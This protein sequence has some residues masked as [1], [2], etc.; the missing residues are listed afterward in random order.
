[1][2]PVKVSAI[3]PNYNSL[4][5]LDKCVSMIRDSVDEIIIGDDNSKIKPEYLDPKIS[6]V[7]NDMNRGAAYCR[8]LGI[9]MAV[10][11]NI[12]CLDNDIYIDYEN[13]KALFSNIPKGTIYYPKQISYDFG[14]VMCPLFPK[15]EFYLQNSSIFFFNRGDLSKLDE[16]FDEN[17]RIYHEDSDFFFR[18]YLFGIKT[19]YLPNILAKHDAGKNIGVLK[20]REYLK[21]RN[22][23][24]S[25]LKFF[26][27][28]NELKEEYAFPGYRCVLGYIRNLLLNR[29]DIDKKIYKLNAFYLFNLLIICKAF[30]WNLY[31]LP[32]I[33]TKNLRLK[34]A[35]LQTRKD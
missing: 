31:M 10:N 18:C 34:N 26:G 15:E 8:N 27:I 12:L 4:D 14:Y 28:S 13:L 35:L 19:I 3:I 32:E 5:K 25:F 9:K 2:T 17:Y 33:V 30:F 22:S 16:L 24:Y 1:M 29:V 11:D 6:V 23:I 20:R 7:L 21:L